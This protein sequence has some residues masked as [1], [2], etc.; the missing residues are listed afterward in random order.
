MN[1]ISHFLGSLLNQI[2]GVVGN[3]GIAIILITLFV[4]I[5]MIPLTIKSTKSQMQMQAMN[6]KLKEIQQKYKNNPEKLNQMTMDLYKEYNINPMAGCL[7]LLIQM[8][9]LFAFFSTLRDPAQF[10]FG[11]EQAQVVLNEG[12]L[13][14]E[15][16]I[17][18]DVINIGGINLPFILP[19]LAAATTFFDMKSNLA[20]TG[21]SGKGG[22]D[23]SA[24]TM[25]IMIYMMPAM[26]LFWG[27]S[28]PAGLSIYIAVST[29]FS[30]VQRRIMEMWKKREQEKKKDGTLKSAQ[31]KKATPANKANVAEK[32]RIEHQNKSNSPATRKKKAG[33]Q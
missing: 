22:D 4:K 33:K 31:A 20:N 24:S 1:A 13:W 16:L 5:I 30:I 10:V 19:I 18:P 8:P 32:S 14:M 25:K 29:F 12:F 17:N 2:Y 26:I 9:I 21:S 11:A 3:Y 23:P 27:V 7:P 6:P 28:M 15:N